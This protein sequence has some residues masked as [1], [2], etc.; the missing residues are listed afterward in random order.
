MKYILRTQTIRISKPPANPQSAPDRQPAPLPP[1]AEI[2]SGSV[3]VTP[4]EDR[5]C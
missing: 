1:D 5:C 2:H 4:F 3:P